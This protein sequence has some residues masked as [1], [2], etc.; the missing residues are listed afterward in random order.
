MSEEK[1]N[2]GKKIA[3]AEAERQV[4]E[5]AKG[6]YHAIS[7]ELVTGRKET[8]CGVYVKDRGWFFDR[9]FDGAIERLKDALGVQYEISDKAP[10]AE[11]MEVV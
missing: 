1:C 10:T 7:Y 6:N 11:D 2:C 8:T 9:T 4:A 5:L 3:F